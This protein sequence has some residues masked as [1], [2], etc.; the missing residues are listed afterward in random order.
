MHKSIE[1]QVKHLIAHRTPAPATD[2]NKRTTIQKEYGVKRVY[3]LPA[4]LYTQFL[5]SKAQGEVN[6]MVEF[7]QQLP[8]DLARQVEV[9]GPAH[10]LFDNWFQPTAA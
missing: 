9:K 1:Q 5:N 8:T 3:R 4:A 10:R 7:I 2:D 6:T